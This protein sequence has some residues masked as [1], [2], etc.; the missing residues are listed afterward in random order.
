MPGGSWDE[1]VEL[2]FRCP[3][4]GLTKDPEKVV[5]EPPE[6]PRQ[7]LGM[8][9]GTCI[10]YKVPGTSDVPPSLTRAVRHGEPQR[11]PIG[12]ARTELDQERE[13]EA[14]SPGTDPVSGSSAALRKTG[15]E[16][17]KHPPQD[18]GESHNSQ[19]SKVRNRLFS[20]QS[21]HISY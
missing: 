6:L 5:L 17:M 3:A 16:M 7:T 8:A 13:R 14:L 1:R 19:R 12:E 20:E 9:L 18:M 10:L 15:W 2:V 21:H 11:F 4:S